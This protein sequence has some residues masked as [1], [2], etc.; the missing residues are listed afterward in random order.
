MV[1][2]R[3]VWGEMSERGVAFGGWGAF[4][5]GNGAKSLD[6]DGGKVAFLS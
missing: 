6:G 5:G 2:E 1:H 3:G 4:E